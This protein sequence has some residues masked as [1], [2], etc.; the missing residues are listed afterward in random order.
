MTDGNTP[1][2]K[3]E[4]FKRLHG[5]YRRSDEASKAQTAED[6]VNARRYAASFL[7]SQGE[8][9]Q[10]EALNTH[11]NINRLVNGEQPFNQSMV[12][13]LI[14]AGKTHST[15]C[16]FEVFNPQ[17]LEAIIGDA[18][19]DKLSKNFVGYT[20]FEKKDDQWH[21]ERVE[22]H[23]SY[24][25]F[26]LA[27]KGDENAANRVTGYSHAQF[28]KESAESLKKKLEGNKSLKK[29]TV[30]IVANALYNVYMHFRIPQ[31]ISHKYVE[32]AKKESYDGF[33]KMFKDDKERAVYARAN[34][35]TGANEL[36]KQGQE[37][38][39]K[40]ANLIA[41]IDR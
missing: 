10:F 23:R 26:L 25:D 18:P 27:E 3:F 38:I 28:F 19:T 8:G 40:A 41:S 13:L 39:D 30:S 12:D 22:A 20:P 9:T 1:E 21:N 5:E 14:N 4:E 36:M 16:L 31:E 35:V 17:G 33:T 2:N 29:E 11:D 34:I 7:A 6:R 15:D 24:F 32:K 37:G